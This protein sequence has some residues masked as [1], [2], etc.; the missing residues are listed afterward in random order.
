MAQVQQRLE[1]AQQLTVPGDVYGDDA[2]AGKT[3]EGVFIELIH[4]SDSY[5]TKTI[6][7][8]LLMLIIWVMLI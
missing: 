6:Y 1:V 8:I 3:G 2:P 4:F 5:T 7:I